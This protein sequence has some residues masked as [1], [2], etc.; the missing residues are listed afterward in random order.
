MLWNSLIS[1]L[2]V[3]FAVIIIG[4]A[5]GRIKI[6]GIALDL[7]GVLIAAVATGC[8]MTLGLNTSET[9]ILS[10]MQ[11]NMKMLSSLGTALFVSVIGIMA[12]YSADLKKPEDFK[13]IFIGALMV[14]FSFA[15]MKAIVAF[16]TEISISKLLG[17]VCGALTTTPGLSAV[18]ELE[19]VNA[20]EAVL[21]YGCTYLFG[22]VFT[23]FVVQILTRNSTE[24]FCC[25]KKDECT[26]SCKASF[27]GLLQIAATIVLGRVIG[28]LSIPKLSFSLGDSGGMLCVG[29]GIGAV[30]K[31]LLP[32]RTA[33][34]QSFNLLRNFGLVLFF[35]GTGIPAGMQLS[36]GIEIRIVIYGIL[37]TVV[38]IMSCRVFYRI[39][40]KKDKHLLAT[41]IAGGMTSTPAI[42]VLIRKHKD[43][44]LSR[45]S[46]AY[47]GALVTIIFLVRAF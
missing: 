30:V 11:L 7:A 38:P 12:G 22:V 28:G 17:A 6:C 14:V 5:F 20:K 21:G 8:I 13:A 32:K 44:S 41:V 36:I 34:I 26:V 19:N 39:L 16:D 3:A 46:L 40:L 27:D 37:M 15:T 43:I 1:P 23:V 29:I 24:I 9:D 31:R 33:Q 47:V 4:Y 45:Y 35:V 2:S 42:G 10:E 25:N 18:C